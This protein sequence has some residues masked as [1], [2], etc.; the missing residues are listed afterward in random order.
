M[1][2]YSCY[3]GP[4]AVDVVVPGVRANLAELASFFGQFKGL[5]FPLIEACKGLVS[6]GILLFS[7]G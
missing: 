6:G 7:V 4:L 1:G 5:A 3:A 2:G